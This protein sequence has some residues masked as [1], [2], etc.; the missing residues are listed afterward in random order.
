MTR[1]WVRPF[2]FLFT[3]GWYVALSLVVPTGIGY[4]LDRG[5]FE[6]TPLLT[7]VGLGL[8]TLVA[9]TGL[10]RMLKRFQTEQSGQNQNKTGETRQK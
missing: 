10:Y 4:W 8:G 9:F 2:W 5:V 7:L 3:F 6:S 1:D